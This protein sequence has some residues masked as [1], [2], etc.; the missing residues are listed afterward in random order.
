[1]ARMANVQDEE[2]IEAASQ[3][4]RFI[5]TNLPA[6]CAAAR[7]VYARCW[8]SA[9]IALRG[10]SVG[11]IET[12]RRDA[13]PLLECFGAIERCHDPLEA[14]FDP[15]AWARMGEDVELVVLDRP[16]HAGADLFGPQSVLDQVAH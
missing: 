8:R 6:P 11:G 3:T 4:R 10:R 12:P 1:M 14:P 2:A 16:H 7:V 5:M 9:S 15:L 13:E